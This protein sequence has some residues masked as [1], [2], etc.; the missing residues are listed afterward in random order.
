[1]DL[2]KYF[3]WRPVLETGLD[4]GSN[5]RK[6]GWKMTFLGDVF[7]IY[8]RREMAFD[9]RVMSRKQLPF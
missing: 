2:K 7:Y 1:M 6:R 3:W 4:F 5:V 9:G 8:N